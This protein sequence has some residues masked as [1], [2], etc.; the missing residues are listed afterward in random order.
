MRYNWTLLTPQ[1]QARA[2]SR[3]LTR[4]AEEMLGTTG[5][6]ELDLD[7]ARDALTS[8]LAY[9]ATQDIAAT[10]V[11]F[12]HPQ[13][14]DDAI[15]TA[16]APVASLTRAFALVSAS[17]LTVV[18]APGTYAEAAAVVWPTRKGVKVLGAGSAFTSIS[19]T[20]TRVFTVTPG[21]QTSTW[22][23]HIEGVEIDHS[24]GSAQGG[25][26]FSN[27]AMTKKLLFSVVNCAFVADASTDKS[28]DVATHTDADNGIRIYISGDGTQK[29][30]EGAIYFLVKNNGDRLNLDQLWLRGVITTSTDDK[31]MNI[32]IRR[33]MIPKGA[34]SA[35]GHSSQ[36]ITSVSSYGWTDF[37]NDTAE[38]YAAADTN[39]FEGSHTEVIVA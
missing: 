11:I 6:D 38:L 26:V 14:S 20:G 7:T 18:M 37:N 4:A 9:I 2:A 23:G 22:E 27:A 36:K 8:E 24:A 30:I 33:C 34:A 28:I 25:I 1:D 19:A 35:G 32:R 5:A 15:G 31:P 12:V 29:E 39:D 16:L 10:G 17:R 21:A 3:R 13:G